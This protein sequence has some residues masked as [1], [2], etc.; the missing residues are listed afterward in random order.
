MMHLDKVGLKLG[1]SVE[2]RRTF[3]SGGTKTQPRPD[4]NIYELLQAVCGPNNNN[5]KWSYDHVRATRAALLTDSNSSNST[6]HTLAAIC[7]LL[8]GANYGL[9]KLFSMGYTCT[10]K[11]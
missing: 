4:T 10:L 2:R 6:Q 7:L 5:T 3:D 8:T 9:Q 1:F 11:K